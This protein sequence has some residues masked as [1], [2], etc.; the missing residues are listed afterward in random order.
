MGIKDR[1]KFI[2]RSYVNAFLDGQNK[3]GEVRRRPKVETDDPEEEPFTFDETDFEA[4]WE[5]FQREQDERASRKSEGRGTERG[6][7]KGAPSIRKCYESLEVPFGS[8][9][10]TVKKAYKK[11]MMRYHPDRQGGD[12]EKIKAATRVAQ[13]LTES[14]Q[15]LKK[16]LEKGTTNR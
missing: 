11:Q 5:A 8:D 12:P 4:Q 16:H 13:I 7:S 1:I 15:I 14:Y 10:E 9:F 3:S 2:A 6:S